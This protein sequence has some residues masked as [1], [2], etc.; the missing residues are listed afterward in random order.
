MHRKAGHIPAL[1]TQ[2][3]CQIH[4]NEDGQERSILIPHLGLYRRSAESFRRR[5]PALA[6]ALPASP[7]SQVRTRRGMRESAQGGG[8]VIERERTEG[9]Q[10]LL[11]HPARHA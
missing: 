6:R 8:S 2:H 5:S 11:E 3:I 9:Q 10:G 7:S 4:T 1:G